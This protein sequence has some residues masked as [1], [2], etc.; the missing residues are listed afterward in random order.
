MLSLW[1][2]VL[3]TILVLLGWITFFMSPASTESRLGI[4][5]TLV[6][7][8]NVFQACVCLS[9]VITGAD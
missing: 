8:I 6:L 5:L 1:P 7:A 4:A 2:T 9:L 3:E